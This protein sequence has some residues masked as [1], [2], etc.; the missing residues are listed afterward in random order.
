[1][2]KHSPRSHRRPLLTIGRHGNLLRPRG[3]ESVISAIESIVYTA[4]RVARDDEPCLMVPAWHHLTLALPAVDEAVK[5]EDDV[6]ITVFWAFHKA[7]G[8]DVLVALDHRETGPAGIDQRYVVMLEARG[9]H[10]TIPSTM[11]T[12]EPVPN[13]NTAHALTR[14]GRLSVRWHWM[15]GG[16]WVTSVVD[17]PSIWTARKAWRDILMRSAFRRTEMVV[18]SPTHWSADMTGNSNGAML[19]SMTGITK[20]EIQ[21]QLE[22]DQAEDAL[23]EAIGITEVGIILLVQ[24]TRE[25][26][27]LKRVYARFLPWDKIPKDFFTPSPQRE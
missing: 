8:I 3:H 11:M 16:E 4:P 27:G 26:Q 10:Y 24:N 7:L 13:A 2:S 6:Q 20:L 17:G 25:E 22:I 1:M 15:Q 5:I 21:D 12:V 14:N 19:L 23:L 18:I 9:E